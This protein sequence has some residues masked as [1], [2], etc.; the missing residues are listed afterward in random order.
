CESHEVKQIPVQVPPEVTVPPRMVY[1]PEGEFILGKPED[2][3]TAGGIQVKTGAYLIDRYEVTRAEYHEFDPDHPYSEN[4][5]QFPVS[6]VTWYEADEYC[7]WQGKRLPTEREWEKAARGTDGRKW[8]WLIYF[9]H[10]NTGF[11]GFLPEPVDKREEWISPYGVYGMGHNVWEWTESWYFYDGQ[12]AQEV[13][14]FKVIRG[15]LLQTHLSVR[16]SPTYFRNYMEPE[17]AYNFIGF[18]CAK[19]VEGEEPRASAD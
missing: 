15:G 17:A 7:R 11:S 5:A 6:L 4:Q 9:E 13:K 14:K 1:I 3:R 10:P 2:R 18:R 19:D 12:P 8:P 16:F